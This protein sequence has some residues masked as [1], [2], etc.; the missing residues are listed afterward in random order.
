MEV[1]VGEAGGSEESSAAFEVV[2][3]AAG[4]FG[5]GR[6]LRRRRKTVRRGGQDGGGRGPDGRATW[7]HRRPDR[8][9]SPWRVCGAERDEGRGMWQKVR[10]DD[11]D[12]H[13]PG[14][15]GSE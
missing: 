9:G 6:K 13:G 2:G 7:S 4:P 15:R 3:V 5:L 8:R 10:E 14:A 11:D 12:G 1:G